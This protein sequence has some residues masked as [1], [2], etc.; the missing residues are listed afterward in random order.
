MLCPMIYSVGIQN[1]VLEAMAMGI[2]VVVAAQTAA[3]LQ[4][5]PGRDLLVAHSVQEFADVALSL[6]HDAKLRT[7]L[8][9][10][11]REYVERHHD[12]SAV[13]D[14]LVDIY[15]QA[16]AGHQGKR[17]VREVTTPF[18]FSGSSV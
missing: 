9:Q 14:R 15:Q 13:T 12:W 4:A 16:I 18:V 10:R 6:M 8:S 5:L 1:K 17:S 7:A 11:G 2:P 3:S